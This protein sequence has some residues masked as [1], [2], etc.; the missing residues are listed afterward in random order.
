MMAEAQ[1]PQ[2]PRSSSSG[3]KATADKPRN[4]VDWPP[5]GKPRAEA[6]AELEEERDA[7]AEFN[8]EMTEIQVNQLKAIKDKIGFPQPK[9]DASKAREEAK[10]A[11]L[12]MTDPKKKE[13][14]LKGEIKA[15]ADRDKAAAEKK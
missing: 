12:A 1:T 10:E 2:Q 15:R 9:E 5:E 3:E 11:F 8:D 6:M 13:A 4:I 14:A 7:Q